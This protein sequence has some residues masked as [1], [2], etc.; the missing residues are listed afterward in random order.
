MHPE[1]RRERS[2]P[3]HTAVLEAIRAGDG[4]A[5]SAAMERLLATVEGY[6]AELATD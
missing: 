2:V 3:E 6:A 1:A 4:A 5:A